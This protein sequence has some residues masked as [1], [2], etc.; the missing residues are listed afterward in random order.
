MFRI[1]VQKR[2]FLIMSSETVLL[3]RGFVILPCRQVG[4]FVIHAV[5]TP[6]FAD[7]TKTVVNPSPET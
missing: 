4:C 3:A 2:R 7:K 5:P 1:V 6:R